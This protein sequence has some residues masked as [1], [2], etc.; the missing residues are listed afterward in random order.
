MRRLARV[1]VAAS[2]A[3]MGVS[4]LLGGPSVAA[5]TVPG[6]DDTPS[7]AT[8]SAASELAPV[9]VLQV[10]AFAAPGS[11][12]SLA[13]GVRARRIRWNT[14]ASG[15]AGDCQSAHHAAHYFLPSLDA[16]LSFQKMSY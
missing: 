1:L 8:S 5:S 3:V 4:G 11:W 7:D 16:A 10:S 15:E 12:Y 14:L 9:D 2:F 6:D 13:G